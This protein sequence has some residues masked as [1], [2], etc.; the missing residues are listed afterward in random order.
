MAQKITYAPQWHE[1]GYGMWTSFDTD[2]SLGNIN[3]KMLYHCMPCL[4]GLKR[5][6]EKSAEELEI[7]PA[8]NC[9]KVV[10]ITDSD[11]RSRQVL[12]EIS[13]TAPEGMMLVGKYGG[14]GGSFNTS[15]IIFYVSE[16]L[17]WTKRLL[18]NAME[19]VYPAGE[20][21]ASRACADVHGELFRGHDNWE[22]VMKPEHPE[23]RQQ[24][25]ETIRGK[26]E[27]KK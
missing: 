1:E 2:P 16:D 27:P 18:E 12:N 19:S 21:R 26:L 23:K 15:A 5:Q 14:T 4:E 22:R 24:V 20:V 6:L 8:Y 3:K 13:R 17:R 11:E 10:G 7:G 25:I 9:F